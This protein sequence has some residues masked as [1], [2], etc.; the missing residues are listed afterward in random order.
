MFTIDGQV[1]SRADILT[2]NDLNSEDEVKVKLTATSKKEK[3][4]GSVSFFQRS[5]NALMGAADAVR[6]AAVKSAFGDDN[7][8][9]EALTI[10]ADGMIW[11]GCA[12]GYLVQWD[13]N[14]NRLQEFHYANSP[15]MCLCTFGSRLWAG[16]ANGMIQVL[17]LEGNLIGSW[18]AH[19]SPVIKLAVGNGFVFSLA[20]HGGIRGWSLTSPGSLDKILMSEL[21]ERQTFYTKRENVRVLAGTW[22][23]GQERACHDSLIAWLG[24][25][26]SEVSLVVVGLQEV[27]MGAGFLAMA[28]AKETVRS[29]YIFN[30]FLCSLSVISTNYVFFFL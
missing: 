7:R 20:N 24:G 21:M 15:V 2:V 28:A 11:M 13:G 29:Q 4:Q 1:D 10:S 25:A 8:R 9:A 23:V 22:N 27:E 17:D 3:T 18:S 5:R 16:Y 12:N 19:S 26:A 6:R 30:A 14:G